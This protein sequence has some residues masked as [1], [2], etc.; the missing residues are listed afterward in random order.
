MPNCQQGER[1][2]RMGPEA[3]SSSELCYL[4][5]WLCHLKSIHQGAVSCTGIPASQDARDCLGLG[6]LTVALNDTGVSVLQIAF[7]AVQVAWGGLAS[8]RIHQT[9]L[10]VHS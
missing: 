10:T 9:G 4:G 6:P 5:I 2:V 1:N 8:G 7:G 3:R